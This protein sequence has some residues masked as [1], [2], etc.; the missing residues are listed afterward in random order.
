[1]GRLQPIEALVS[2]A[3]LL[4]SQQ[5]PRPRTSPTTTFSCP[6]SSFYRQL[7]SE[8]KAQETSDLLSAEHHCV[9]NTRHQASNSL[10]A[11]S[12]RSYASVYMFKPFIPGSTYSRPVSSHHITAM[13]ELT[14]QIISIDP[15][16]TDHSPTT[17]VALLGDAN[18]HHQ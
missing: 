10:R 5:P 2:T 14:D 17:Q 4:S 16:G 18:L 11:V 1:M 9:C 7:F 6:G 15:R 8:Q 12:F 13:G 3:E